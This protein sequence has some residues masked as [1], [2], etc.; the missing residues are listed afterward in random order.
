[1]CRKR[2]PGVVSHVLAIAHATGATVYD[3]LAGENQLKNSF[4]TDRYEL[5]WQIA[6]QPRLKYRLESAARHAKRR[7]FGRATA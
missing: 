2:R 4:A 7:L 6:R 5:A 1:M 3:F